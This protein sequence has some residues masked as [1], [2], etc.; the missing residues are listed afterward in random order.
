[1]APERIGE[2]GVE[3]RCQQELDLGTILRDVGLGTTRG[4]WLHFSGVVFVTVLLLDGVQAFG[5]VSLVDDFGLTDIADNARGEG[6]LSAGQHAV[7][8]VLLEFGIPGVPQVVL[9]GDLCN[10]LVNALLDH[11]DLTCI[12]AVSSGDALG[13][14]RG[15]RQGAGVV[16]GRWLLF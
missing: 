3:R 8:I 10:L 15:K 4:C 12:L 9:L 14:A 11:V 6:V 16:Q 7:C 2:I 1:M 5:V 13:A